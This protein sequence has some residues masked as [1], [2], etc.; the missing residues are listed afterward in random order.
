MSTRKILS[1]LLFFVFSSCVAHAQVQ[2]LLYAAEDHGYIYIY[3]IDQGHTLV[4]K[5]AVPGAGNFKGI[6][7]DARRGKLY[8]SSN[9]GDQLVCVD[10][11]TEK[12]DWSL[13]V[14]EY[15]DSQAITPDGKYIYLPKRYGG[16]WDVIDADLKK[17]IAFIPVPYGNPHNT[18]CSK[19][20]SK[21]YLAA[22]GNENLYVADVSTHSIVKTVGPFDANTESGWGWVDKKD[23]PKGIRPFAVSSD[24][25]FC[26]VNMDG[27]LGYE[28]GDLLTGKRVGRVEVQGFP[29]IRGNHL[30]TSHGVNL[31]P[32]GKEIW[33]SND[34]APYLH[35]FD[36]TVTPHKQIADIKFNKKNGWITF[37]IDGDYCYPSSGDVIDTRSKKI[38]GQVVES[39]KLL[40]ID[41]EGGV[42]VQA[43][44]R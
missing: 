43:G 3:D 13:P 32:G 29:K 10:L 16:G 7:A 28:I 36:C 5:F 23:S 18:W 26:Y 40:E 39:E 34:A 27:I 41:F 9:T 33:V 24:D 4:R 30:T 42:P 1:A 44:T 14:N 22:L 31:P 38:I 11:K 20:G 25:R 17:V 2:R 19:D 12:I 15:A 8:L 35:V 21:M 37:S 6:S